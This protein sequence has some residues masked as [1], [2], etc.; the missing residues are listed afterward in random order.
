MYVLKNSNTWVLL[1]LQTQARTITQNVWTTDAK[2]QHDKNE[3][4]MGDKSYSW[5]TY[6]RTCLA[7]ELDGLG[8]LISA[9]T[10]LPVPAAGR[11][12][13][14]DCSGACPSPSWLLP[15]CYSSGPS[16]SSPPIWVTAMAP[17]VGSWKAWC[18]GRWWYG[19]DDDGVW[20]ATVAEPYH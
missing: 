19:G 12:F 7:Q 14:G 11:G 1:G 6:I 17:E 2:V 3:F 4:P 15:F 13:V 16:T 20:S 5:S 18:S 10:S 8:L 9:G